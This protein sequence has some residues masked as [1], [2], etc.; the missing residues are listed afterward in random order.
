MALRCTLKDSVSRLWREMSSIKKS[1]RLLSPRAPLLTSA[2]CA[3]I[4]NPPALDTTFVHEIRFE[5][6]PVRLG[7]G[8]FLLN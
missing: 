5:N 1:S 2:H 6:P 7:F 3:P 4:L 8:L